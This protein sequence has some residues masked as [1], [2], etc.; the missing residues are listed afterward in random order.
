MSIRNSPGPSRRVLFLE[1][2]FG[3][4]HRAFAEG[5]KDHS[6]HA[7]DLV[8]LPS[9]FWKWRMRGAALHYAHTVQNPDRY[10]CLICSDM[11]SL[12]DLK[13]LWGDSSPPSILY[14]HENQLSYP[15]PEGEKLDYHFAFTNLTSAIAAD[16]VLFNSHF[17]QREFYRELTLFTKK[18]PEYRPDWAIDEIRQKSSVLYPGCVSSPISTDTDTTPLI[19]WNHRWEFDKSPD[20]FFRALDRLISRGIAFRLAILGENFQAVPKPFIDAKTRLADRII[21]YG[22]LENYESYRMMLERGWVVVSTAIQEN[23]GISVIEAINAGCH[24]ILPRRLSYPEIIPESSHASVLYDDEDDLV[25][26]LAGVLDSDTPRD[27][28]SLVLHTAR[29]AWERLAPEYDAIIDEIS[30]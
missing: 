3:G 6:R 17:H 1:P 16:R 7:I 28:T 25:E 4:S 29:Y 8:T 22:Y 23:F 20:V 21:H 27:T 30:R 9:R 15:V 14:F 26:K 5:L 24:P 12:L 2:F 13:G 18:L 10:D 11:M 19:I